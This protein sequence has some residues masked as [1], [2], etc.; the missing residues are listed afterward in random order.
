MAGDRGLAFIVVG[1]IS[2]RALW[3]ANARTA[4]PHQRSAPRPSATATHAAVNA[5][6]AANP[7]KDSEFI[8]RTLQQQTAEILVGELAVERASA[9]TLREAAERITADHSRLS[10]E[11]KRI[12]SLKGLSYSVEPSADDH[13]EYTY[14]AA[15]TGAQFDEEYAS[16]TLRAKN[17]AMMEFR[18]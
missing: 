14:L 4:A 15:L 1:F 16:H 7:G 9:T 18:E 11:L 12:A 17:T 5:S 3:F 10:A 13:A 6:P 8:H 2:I